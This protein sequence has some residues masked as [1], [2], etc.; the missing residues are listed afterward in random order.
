MVNRSPRLQWVDLRL[1]AGL[2]LAWP[3]ITVRGRELDET[4]GVFGT[5][6]HASGAA[7]QVAVSKHRIWFDHWL[8]GTEMKLTGAWAR[9]PLDGG[10]ADVPNVAFHFQIGAG[11]VF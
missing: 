9:V 8:V 2:V 3:H 4:R 7:V 5:G 10:S 1:G 11:Y 6:W